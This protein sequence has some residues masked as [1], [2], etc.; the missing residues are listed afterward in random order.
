MNIYDYQMS[1]SFNDLC[2]R[3]SDQYFQTY[4]SLETTKPIEAK[5]Y[6]A[7]SCDEGMKMNINGLCHMIKM[8]DMPIYG[9][10][11]KHLLFWKQKADV[12]KT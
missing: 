10:N 3:H 12:L 11:F 2:R 1:R 7:S 9:G 8:A 4:F 5:F 6:V